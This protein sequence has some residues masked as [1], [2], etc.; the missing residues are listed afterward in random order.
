MSSLEIKMNNILKKNNLPYKF[1]GNGEVVIGKK[2]P[3]FVN[4][5]GEKIAIEVYWTKHKDIF[6]GGTENWKIN[7]QNIFNEYG[8]KVLFFDETQIKEDI[9]CNIL[10]R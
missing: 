2:C 9:I 7:R 1:V 8:W 6:R 3:D 5:D 4:V 10:K